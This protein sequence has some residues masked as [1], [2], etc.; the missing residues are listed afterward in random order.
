MCSVRHTWLRLGTVQYRMIRYYLLFLFSCD[1]LI[2]VLY[3]IG[4][5]FWI[6]RCNELISWTSELI[7]HGFGFHLQ[8]VHTMAFCAILF[9][10]RC[11]E[12]C[13]KL[14][15]SATT[16]IFFFFIQKSGIPVQLYF[17]SK[18]SIKYK[19]PFRLKIDTLIAF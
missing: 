2:Q 11:F 13:L 6:Q 16:I 18:N 4:Y 3:I 10:L 15:S 12:M 8:E 7:G 1:S 5:G 19:S 9:D 17:C 14:R